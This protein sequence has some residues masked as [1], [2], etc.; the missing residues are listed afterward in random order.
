MELKVTSGDIAQAQVDGIIVNLFEG[1][2]A[3]G[4]GTGAVDAALGGAISQL[5]A[6]GEVKGKLNETT[7]IH[8][9]GRIPSPRVMVV[10]LG[11]PADFNLER[12]RQVSATALK[13]LR[14]AGARR[15]GTIVHGAGIA[16][17]PPGDCAQALAEGAVLGLY[18]FDE[19]KKADPETKDVDELL[20]V[21]H[22]AGK[23]PALEAGVA[24]GSIVAEAVTFTR[25]MINQP[26]SAL[27]P[28]RMA[29]LAQQVAQE[30]GLECQVLD[31]EQMAE[32]GMGGLLGV[33][34]GSQQP[35]KFIALRYRGDPDNKKT[36]LGLVGK[37]ITF[38]SG[39]I[40]I[41]P[42]EGM[43][44][45]KTDMSGGAAVIG[46][47]K[48][49]AQLKPKLNVAGLV[50]ATENM[51]SGSALK[52]GD[53]LRALNGKTMEIVNTDAEG[54]LILA[55]ALSYARKEGL[56]PVID[57]ATLTGACR[58]ALGEVRSGAFANNQAF[59]GQVTQA[60]DAAGEKIWPMPMDDEY[61][62]Q[63]K[64]DVADVKNT[65]G[66]SAGAVTAA[67]FLAEFIEDTPWVHLDI[68]GTARVD[69]EQ[70]YIPKGGSGVGVRTMVNL[71]LALAES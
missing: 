46:A 39:G 63:F 48:A 59:L 65:G 8:T 3:P 9:L 17:L 44:E 50:P 26:A 52:P 16:G 31:R 2:T 10:G 33:A 5:I 67:L 38:D 55:D 37:G 32:L 30:G 36:T 68:A 6:Q 47:M 25:D 19:Y 13:A 20:L 7:L 41:K 28:T 1:V 51:P 29:E 18:R 34:Q 42:A 53:I 66:R 56:S 58:I 45:M 35:P 24:R 43:E 11:K 22:D 14:R 62:D 69:K 23:L 21:E 61:K 49:L 71:A 64:S 15:V 70:P 27:T 57:L 54:R 12:A 4:G 40:S 60:A